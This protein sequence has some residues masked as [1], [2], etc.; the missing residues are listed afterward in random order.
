MTGILMLWN[1]SQKPTN[2]PVFWC[3]EKT[4]GYWLKAIISHNMEQ[5]QLTNLPVLIEY[6]VC[7][8]LQ[9]ITFT[10]H[11]LITA[12][13][14]HQQTVRLPLL[15]PSIEQGMSQCCIPKHS[16]RSNVPRQWALL[17]EYGTKICIINRELKHWNEDQVIL[18]ILQVML[19]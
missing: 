10:G 9:S 3:G 7:Y 14:C 19:T 13:S 12:T 11:V 8:L 15:P 1:I 2:Q 16:W 6:C 5:H 17:H 4:P 18:D